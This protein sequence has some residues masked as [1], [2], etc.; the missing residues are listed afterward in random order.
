MSLSLL[1]GES[2]F[3]N[4]RMIEARLNRF[5]VESLLPSLYSQTSPLTISSWE[6]PGE[7]VS[8]EHATSQ[9]FS[10]FKIGQ[11]WGLPWG[12]TWFHVTGEVPAQ[13]VGRDLQIEILVD[14]GFEGSGSSVPVQYPQWDR[15]LGDHQPGFQAEGLA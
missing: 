1:E 8:F 4:E 5:M 14:L 2:V 10:E 9:N 3:K 7:P 12:T 13:W 15:N 11:S 6:A